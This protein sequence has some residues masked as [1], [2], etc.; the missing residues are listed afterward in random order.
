MM[1]AAFAMLAISATVGILA[2]YMLSRMDNHE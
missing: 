2:A 1:L